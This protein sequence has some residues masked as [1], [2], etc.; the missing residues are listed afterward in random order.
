MGAMVK[1]SNASRASTVDG[2]VNCNG[3]A[4]GRGVA[5]TRNDGFAFR[6]GVA[7]TDTTCAGILRPLGDW[8][9][10]TFPRSGVLFPRFTASFLNFATFSF[11]WIFELILVCTSLN[12]KSG[13]ANNDE[14]FPSFACVQQ[15]KHHHT[16]TS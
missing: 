3:F 6:R 5:S 9:P 4:A 10:L 14:C 2:C 16:V 12:N 8:T 13:C 1:G 11:P 7:C 15:P